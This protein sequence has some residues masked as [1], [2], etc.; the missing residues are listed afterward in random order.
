MRENKVQKELARKTEAIETENKRKAK[1]EIGGLN[2]KLK[3]G[4]KT[5]RSENNGN[6]KNRK[7]RMFDREEQNNI[8]KLAKIQ[9]GF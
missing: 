5:E 1:K 9:R 8:E 6:N 4:N 2:W 7:Q 3:Y